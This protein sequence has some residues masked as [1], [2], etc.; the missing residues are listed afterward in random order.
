M[1]YFSN[2][3]DGVK[4][5]SEP[6]LLRRVIINSIPNFGVASGP[7]SIKGCCPYVQLFKCGK[8]VATAAP[9]AGESDVSTG[10]GGSQL[11]LKWV[12]CM[13]GSI[14]FNVD[15]PVQGDLLLRC[16][17]ADT[18]GARVSMF[19]AAFHTG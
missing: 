2:M 4:P 9:P 6:L 17:H 12:A 14:S 10:S 15:S 3:L 8:L 18:S 7:D 19:R 11:E 1:Q 5:R 13:E 16:R